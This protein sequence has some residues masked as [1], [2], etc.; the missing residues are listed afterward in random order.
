MSGRCT[1]TSK[2]FI[3]SSESSISICTAADVLAHITQELALYS[4]TREKSV[5][6][7]LH[8]NFVTVRI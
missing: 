4:K 2:V 5:H 7:C 1:A 6:W 8:S 3:S